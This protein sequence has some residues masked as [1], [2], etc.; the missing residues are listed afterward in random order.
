M[1][2][3][4]FSHVA[5]ITVLLGLTFLIGFWQGQASILDLQ[6]NNQLLL[7]TNRLSTQTDEQSVKD[8]ISLPSPLQ[9]SSSLTSVLEP[10]LIDEENSREAFINL[11]G[12][13]ELAPDASASELLD[14]LVAI[15]SSD[16]PDD[17]QYFAKTMDKLRTAV[18]QNPQA[19]QVLLDKFMQADL[20]AKSPYYIISV[21]QG[22]D[23]PN[24]QQ[25]FETLAQQLATDSSS[26]SQ[27]KLL[28]LISSTGLQ[29][30]NTAITGMLTDIALYSNIDTDNRLHALDLLK[31]YQLMQSQKQTIVNDL[32]LAITSMDE[33]QKSYAIENMMRFSALDEREIMAN[34]FLDVNNDL[35]TRIAVLSSLHS[36]TLTPSSS[37]KSQLFEIASNNTDPLSNHAKHAL[38]NVFNITNDEYKVLNNNAAV[39]LPNS[40]E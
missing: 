16:N 10:A 34:E 40:D 28:H 13:G 27:E 14:F 21:L 24:K 26:V 38:M 36:R 33:D 12:L 3:L 22:A 15:A 6:S 39:K 19:I 37:L 35:S 23:I 4:K 7:S 8:A 20:E 5:L 32:K 18:S 31:P 29:E 11:S 2:N 17:M 1:N 30:R 25:V 9:A